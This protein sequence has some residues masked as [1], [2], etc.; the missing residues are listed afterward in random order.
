MSK[1]DIERGTVQ[2]I[3]LRIE[4]LDG[5]CYLA[6]TFARRRSDGCT[7]DRSLRRLLIQSLDQPQGASPRLNLVCVLN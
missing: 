4:S 3:G 7:V 1:L 2:A 6:K 5:Y